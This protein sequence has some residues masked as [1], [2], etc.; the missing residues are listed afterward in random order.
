MREFKKNCFNCIYIR[1]RKGNFCR[2]V[3]KKIADVQNFVCDSFNVDTWAIRLEEKM[4]DKKDDD[5]SKRLL[6]WL[7]G[8]LTFKPVYA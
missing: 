4:A 1:P 3:N 8:S 5:G 6:S 2:V 7:F